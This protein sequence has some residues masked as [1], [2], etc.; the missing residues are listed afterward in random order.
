ML[1]AV[2]DS[3]IRRAF[4]R[5]ESRDIFTRDAHAFDKCIVVAALRLATTHKLLQ[6]LPLTKPLTRDSRPTY[7]LTG[8]ALLSLHPCEERL[9]RRPCEYLLLVPRFYTRHPRAGS[10]AKTRQVPCLCACK[11]SRAILMPHIDHPSPASAYLWQQSVQ[12]CIQRC[13]L[14]WTCTPRRRVPTDAVP[15]R[16]ATCDR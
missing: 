3:V 9:G 13:G 16:R 10:L 1:R 4:Q 14:H 15:G 12:K 8:P 6:T 7:L 11:T 5:R 2:T